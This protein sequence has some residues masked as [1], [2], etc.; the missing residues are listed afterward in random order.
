[1]S[2][3]GDSGLGGAQSGG[4]G[5]GNASGDWHCDS[6][7][8][9]HTV[10]TTS[11]RTWCL[12]SYNNN[13][14]KR[15]QNSGGD[16]NNSFIGFST[17][18]AYFDFNRFHCHWSPRDWQR[19]VNNH[20]GFRP[21]S[22][23]V[24]VYNI[25]VKEVATVNSEKQITNNL[26]STVQI[27]ADSQYA[28][29]YVTS[30]ATEG[31][32]PPFPADVFLLPQ[33]GYCTLQAWANSQTRTTQR[34]AFYCLEYFP[35]KM[36]RT[37]DSFDFTYHF[38]DL[39]FHSGYAP[40]QALNRLA[41]PLI[42]QYLWHFNN[43]DGSGNPDFAKC[44]STNWATKYQNWMPGAFWK[45]QA[46]TSLANNPNQ[47]SWNV[48]NK[49]EV[50]GTL[51]SVRPG[52]NGMCNTD[53]QVSTRTAYDNSM[54]FINEPS[55]PGDSTTRNISAVKIGREDETIPVN[56]RANWQGPVTARNQQGSSTAPTKANNTEKGVHP[57]NVW[58]D[59]DVYLQ[60]PIWAKIPKVDGVFHP[61]PNMGG[62]GC[63]TPPPM[64]LIRNTAVPADP[65]TT[66]KDGPVQSF[67]SQYSTGQV[68][69][70]IEWEVLRESSKRWNPEIQFTNNWENNLII[71]FAPDDSG[72][73]TYNRLIG[74]RYLTQPL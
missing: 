12:P 69:V 34:S 39:P 68:T 2:A 50:N 31:S 25:Q 24:K 37:G 41:N 71:D 40:N 19:L 4:D 47:Q 17:P 72:K 63:K 49:S 43:T 48:G 15:I 42:D 16:Q 65:P 9:G 61:T 26:T 14:Y 46:W 57:G 58:M 27:F 5:V 54:I 53:A 18:W 6:Q 44:V 20:Y 59:R 11:T 30:S 3:T 1:M 67:I 8:M 73:Y 13:L 22:M 55:Q 66:Y 23:H 33:Y 21:R 64:I 35:S 28:L 52:P 45:T 38:P 62:F 29:P 51:D 74:T 60:G 10:R 56:Y 32:L 7:W 70:S 36:L